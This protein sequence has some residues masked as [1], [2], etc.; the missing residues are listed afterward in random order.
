MDAYKFARR[1]KTLSALISYEYTAEVGRL[2][3]YQST[4]SPIQQV[5]G[6][7]I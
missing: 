2:E 6:L 7:N 3:F 1:L 4:I 5:L